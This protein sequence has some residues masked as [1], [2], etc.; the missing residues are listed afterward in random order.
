MMNP[1]RERRELYSSKVGEVS[2]ATTTL[3]PVDEEGV[4]KHYII[5]I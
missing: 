2:S 4:V 5:S 1:I 3:F